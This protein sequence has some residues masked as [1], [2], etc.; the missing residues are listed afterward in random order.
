MLAG[1]LMNWAL[2]RAVELKIV[3]L[4]NVRAALAAVESGNV[5]AGIVYKTDA[6]ISKAVKIAYEVSATEGPKILYPVAMVKDSKNFDASKK[7]LEYLKSEPA[8]AIFK[9]FGF[10]VRP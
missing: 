2:W 10:I 7:F 4:E 6:A 8:L 5:E 3:S 1:I 9:K